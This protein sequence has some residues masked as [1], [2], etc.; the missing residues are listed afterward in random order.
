MEEKNAR[1]TVWEEPALLV[2]STY[3]AFDGGLDRW[4]DSLYMLFRYNMTWS[5]AYSIDVIESRSRG[6]FVSLRINPA[7][8]DELLATMEDLGYRDTKVSDDPIGHIEC[9]DLPDDMP[10]DLVLVG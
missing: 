2:T 3:E 6:V 1:V 8:R 5:F 7:Y 9:T 4:K 10:Y